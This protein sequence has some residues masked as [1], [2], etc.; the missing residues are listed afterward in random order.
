MGLKKKN[1]SRK[2]GLLKGV[3]RPKVM[4]K[5]RLWVMI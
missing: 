5:N 2:K 3:K 4:F 1:Q